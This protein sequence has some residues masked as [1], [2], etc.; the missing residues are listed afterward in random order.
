MITEENNSEIP[1]WRN[2]DQPLLADSANL[3][4]YIYCSKSASS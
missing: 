3:H 4:Q 2:F 1:L